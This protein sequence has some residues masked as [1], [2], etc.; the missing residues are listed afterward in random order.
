MKSV[1][2]VPQEVTVKVGATVRWTNSDSFAH[3]VTASDGSWT[4]TGGPGGMKAGAVYA[5]TFSS[6]GSFDYYCT[7]HSS[8]AGNG[9][10]GHVKVVE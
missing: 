7:V 5:R 4:S 3:D 2:F 1:K 9:M 8:G 6:A 10:W